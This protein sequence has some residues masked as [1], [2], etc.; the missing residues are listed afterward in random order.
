MEP[1]SGEGGGQD[2]VF[3]DADVSS[4]DVVAAADAT[5]EHAFDE[6]GTHRYVC[7][8]HEGIDMKGAVV[9]E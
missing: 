7:R 9:V 5:F 1:S 8:P 3:T 2:V 6:P 4:G